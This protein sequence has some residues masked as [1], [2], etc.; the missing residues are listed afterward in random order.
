M[1]KSFMKDVDNNRALKDKLD[2]VL[3]DKS[4]LE[5]LLEEFSVAKDKYSI[6]L[7]R[8]TSDSIENQGDIK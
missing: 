4:S 6:S 7:M 8:N 2:Q 3:S 1:L 5:S